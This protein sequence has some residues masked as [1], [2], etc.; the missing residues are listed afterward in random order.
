[1]INTSSIEDAIKQINAVRKANKDKW[2][3]VEIHVNNEVILVKFFNTWI[4]AISKDGIK[5]DGTSGDNKV[6]EFNEAIRRVI[7]YK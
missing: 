5:H 7:E 2:R 3:F 4:Q 1:M 6:S